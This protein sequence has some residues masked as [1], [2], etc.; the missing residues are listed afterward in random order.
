MSLNRNSVRQDEV[1]ARRMQPVNSLGDF[2]IPDA[3]RVVIDS[4]SAEE[5][6]FTS[7]TSTL[8]VT[9]PVMR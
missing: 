2:P 7:Q 5:L 9:F 6:C 8:P 1:D 3:L 4:F